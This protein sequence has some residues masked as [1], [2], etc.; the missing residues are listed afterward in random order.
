MPSPNSI[1]RIS[2]SEAAKLFGINPQTVRR[3]IKSQE[4]SYV[5]VRGRYRVNFE[6][7]LKWSQKKTTVRNKLKTN[8]IGQFVEQ[9]KIKNPLYSPNPKLLEKR[10]QEKSGS[11]GAK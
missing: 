1:V 10:V 2:I 3:A 6:S 7:L 9:W 4:V 8:G 11:D 5:V